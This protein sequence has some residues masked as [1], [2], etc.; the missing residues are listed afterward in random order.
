[1]PQLT[2]EEVRRSLLPPGSRAIGGGSLDRELTWT[3]VLRA[4]P[5]A[6]ARIS[7]GELA[8][9]SM[10][11]LAFLRL[12]DPTV[13]LA[14]LL[15]SLAERGVGGALVVGQP[16]PEIAPL[17]DELGLPLVVAPASVN[18]HELD[19]EI[20]R[21][22]TNRK[23]ESYQ[24]E[25][26]IQRRFTEASLGGGGLAAIADAAADLSGK[27]VAF[28]DAT[29]RIRLVSPAPGGAA[30]AAVGAVLER[31]RAALRP[32]EDTGASSSE[33][34]ALLIADSTGDLARLTAPVV[35]VDG[36]G[37]FLSALAPAA[38][39]GDD[40]RLA[41][42][43]AAAACAVELSKEQAVV[44]AETRLLG[45][46]VGDLLEGRFLAEEV[47]LAR[48]PYFGFEPSKPYRVIAFKLDPF[49]PA[50]RVGHPEPASRGERLGVMRELTRTLVE[51]AGRRKSRI[52][53]RAREDAL[54]V[55]YPADRLSERK[56]HRDA[57]EDLRRYL[58]S[59]RPGL[60]LTAGLGRAYPG[61]EG[62]RTAYQEAEQAVRIAQTLL[63]GDRT[64]DFAEMGVY[65]LLLPLQDNPELRAFHD[66]YLG[67][68]R[69]YDQRNKTDLV[70][71]LEAFFACRGNL[72]DTAEHLSLHRNSLAYR[73]RR[74]EEISGRDLDDFEDRLRL[75]LALKIHQIQ[76]L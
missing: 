58:A 56:S 37:G 24:R 17:A 14:Q 63:G 39:F 47:I 52:L 10:E 1:V 43:R 40:D 59:R 22:I 16:P 4:R 19:N 6:F 75:H 61:L 48:A 11:T 30:A 7:G 23:T 32:L 76:I 54:A 38:A 74:I 13:T 25:L 29:Y 70:R 15:R 26:E 64:A 42:S 20:T 8:L 60:R 55:L 12:V 53:F 67:A 5:P 28:E 51:E 3:A 50:G 66:E 46:Y 41:I 21:T 72:Q 34:P 68:L 33:P 35:T 36:L 44:E 62:L 18:V 65:R 71:T 73:I 31:T 9:I 57:V 27:T 45:D 69:A 2:L 49:T